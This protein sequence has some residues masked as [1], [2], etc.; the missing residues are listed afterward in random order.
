MTV[1]CLLQWLC[2]LDAAKSFEMVPRKAKLKISQ[3]R[4]IFN[5]YS[6]ATRK[7]HIK[8][9]YFL[10]FRNKVVSPAERYNA[11]K[12]YLPLPDFYFLLIFVTLKCF[13]SSFSVTFLNYVLIY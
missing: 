12:K 13:G 6:R 5:F 11:V 4:C 8:N 1:N 7:D 3:V 9:I 10:K 2:Q